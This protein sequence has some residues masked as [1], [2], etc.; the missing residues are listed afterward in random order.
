MRGLTSEQVERSRQE[1]GNNDLT[2]PAREKWW[3]L[4][5]SKFDDPIIK[6][7]LLATVLSFIT[8][9]FNG[10][11]TE[12]IGIMLAIFLATFL[13]FINEYRA[14]KEFD[15]LNRLSDSE[16][17][18]AYR[19]GEVTEIPKTEIVV[20]DVLVLEQG[21]EV[22]ADCIILEA[23]TLSVNES[24]LNGESIPAAKLVLTDEEIENQG[25]EGAYPPNRIFRGTTIVEGNAVV[26]VFAVGD[27]TEIGKTARQAM[28]ITGD[29]TPLNRQLGKLGQVIGKV[30]IIVAGILF[31]ALVVRGFIVGELSFSKEALPD[32]LN[33]LLSFFM[34]AVTLIVVAVPEGLAMSVTLSLAYSMRK[35]TADNTLVR[36][37]HACE[38]MGATNVICT[39][40]TGTLTQNIMK[41]GYCSIPVNE[42]LAE[43]IA[44]NSTAHLGNDTIIGNAT[45]GAMLAYLHDNGFD[46]RE[47]RATDNL[48]DRIPFS[49]ERKCMVSIVDSRIAT[50]RNTD[51]YN[52]YVKGAPEYVIEMCG[53]A[54][55]RRDEIM[56]EIESYQ[57]KG[58]RLI[59]FAEKQLKKSDFQGPFA[60]DIVFE[61]RK[62]A[63]LRYCGFA[64][65]AD[66]IREDVP[67]AMKACTDA[68]IEVKIVTGDNTLT[69]VEI[70]RQSGLWKDSDDE[71]AMITGAEFATLDNDK[72]YEAA[73]RIKVMS[74]ARPADKMRLV[75]LL[76]KAGKIVAVT[77]DGT[78]D[79]PALNHAN[80]GLS[81][82]SGTA[83]AKEASDIVLLNDSFASIVKAVQWG[84]SIYLNIQRFIQFQLTINVVALL[85]ALIG[86]FIGIEF[87][88]TVTQM[89]WVNLIMDTFAALALATEPSRV[90]VLNKPPRK[91]DDFIITKKM[92]KNILI[93]GLIFLSVII[94]L[95]FFF[96][97]FEQD[98]AQE[99]L[100][101]LHRWIKSDICILDDHELSLFFTT[102]VL[103]Q[104][105]NLF[106]VRTM[107]TGQS[108]FKNF[109]GNHSFLLI[110]M[111]I[112]VFQIIIVQFGGEFF[113]TVPLALNEWLFIVISTSCV[114]WIGEAIRWRYRINIR[115]TQNNK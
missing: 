18:K 39:D 37:M 105:W 49:T 42:H 115:K 108:A 54:A 106:N 43:M 27:N 86:P 61:W 71:C 48:I 15:I 67:G 101:G 8:G 56:A 66:P 22:P 7:L 95:I 103:M 77:G 110:A 78:N 25:F 26:E 74:R 73:L 14:G 40:K 87:P 19:N 109:T 59:M 13:S 85:T 112:I 47:Y 21:D 32:T 10:S 79:A 91:I 29:E 80:V 5:L 63:P 65:I 36:K 2:P 68:G 83:V 34:I 24:S 97:N 113:R 33:A 62:T 89:L 41:V 92:W 31:A 38:T 20:G 46:Y 100:F 35:M 81:M 45:E 58:M 70:A 88:L 16:P 51:C 4:L 82:G 1:H 114:L 50:N 75:N 102:F 55:D 93:P 60:H 84:R 12:S 76:K 104:F 28:E 64:A 23:I 52:I 111:V 11:M 30:G 90:E 44:S 96:L 99:W 17:V 9:Y 94:F 57:K 69:A 53:E 98:S 3:K 107:G 72:A 6:L